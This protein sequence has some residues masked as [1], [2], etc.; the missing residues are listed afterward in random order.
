MC[1]G[2]RVTSE[3]VL[4]VLWVRMCYGCYGWRVTSEGVLWVEGDK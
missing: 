4:W 1:Y 3:D 2:W